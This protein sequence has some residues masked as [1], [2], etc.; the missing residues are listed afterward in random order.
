MTRR[1]RLACRI[2]LCGLM[3]LALHAPCADAARDVCSHGGSCNGQ[4]AYAP[5]AK[6]FG[7]SKTTWRTWPGEVRLDETFQE[8]VGRERLP[9]PPGQK[10]KPLPK[11]TVPPSGQDPYPQPSPGGLILPPPGGDIFDPGGF[12]ID[13]ALPILPP[14]TD[15]PSTD[16]VLPGGIIPGLPAEPS[17]DSPG[18]I[19]LPPDVPEEPDTGATPDGDQTIPSTPPADE[20][21]ALPAGDGSQLPKMLPDLVARKPI[22][23]APGT[24]QLADR[25]PLPAAPGQRLKEPDAVPAY[26]KPVPA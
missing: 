24:G 6:E 10:Q 20:L 9:T 22:G 19:D 2:A 13:G 15:K 14:D 25:Q 23:G 8:S 26:S 16:P 18:E 1:V 3:L 7:Y 17:L 12:N 4:C 21:P 5:N 11:E